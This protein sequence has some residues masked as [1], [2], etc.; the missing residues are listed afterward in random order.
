M[1]L[2]S[3]SHLVTSMERRWVY[4]MAQLKAR[5]LERMLV[6]K[7]DQLSVGMTVPQLALQM[8]R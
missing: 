2:W 5:W 7:K 6:L 4:K 3:E 1:D 8:D